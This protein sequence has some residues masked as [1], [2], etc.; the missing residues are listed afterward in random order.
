MLVCSSVPVLACPAVVGFRVFLAQLLNHVQVVA[1]EC[2][3]FYVSTCNAHRPLVYVRP[4]AVHA[5]AG[6]TLAELH[7]RCAHGLLQ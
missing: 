2:D 3:V 7:R 6:V 4:S 1:G 5:A